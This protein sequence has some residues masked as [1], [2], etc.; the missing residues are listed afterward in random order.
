VG[1]SLEDFEESYK[2]AVEAGQ[3]N[4]RA[5][6]LL[7]NWCY[8][9]EFVRSAGRGMIEAATGLPIGHMGVQC[10]FSKKNTMHSWLLE[11][12]A[13]DFYLNNCKDCSERVAVGIPNIM[14][15]ITPR[16]EAARVRNQ[17]R[18]AEDTKRKAEQQSRREARALLRDHLKIEETFVLDLLDEL[19]EDDVNR[20][21]PRLEQLANLA[22]ESFTRQIIDHLLPHVLYQQLPYSAPGAKALLRTSL[23]K[24]EKVAVAVKLVGGYDKS[25]DATAVVL[26]HADLLTSDDLSK[27]LRRFTSLALGPPPGMHMGGSDPVRL[28]ATPVKTLYS[29]RRGD[30]CDVVEKLIGDTSPSKIGGAVEI[31]LS[32]LDDD[33]LQKHSRTIFAKLMR[34]R[35]LLPSE[36]RDSSVLYYLREAASRCLD[37]FP[38]EADRIIQSFLADGDDTGKSEAFRIYRSVLE[39]KYDQEVEIGN[40]QRI[41]FKRLLWAAVENPDAQM[42]DATQFFQHSWDEFAPLAVE[43]FDDLIGAAATLSERYEAV[44][45]KKSLEVTSDTLAQMD[46]RSKRTA[47]DSLQGALIEW[48]AVGARTKGRS[49]VQE[50]LDLYRRLPEDQTQMRGNMISHV[51]KLLSGVESL[52]WVLSDWYRALMDESTLVR[53][54]AVQAWEKVPYDL[55]QHFPDLFFEALA[56]SFS[57]P[58]VI[59]HRS[60][61]QALRRRSIPKDK[62]EL[63]KSSIWNLILHYANEDKTNEFTVDCIDALAYLCLSQDERQ[64]RFGEVLTGILLTLEGA[65]LYRAVDRLLYGFRDVP[66]F[67][68]VA[69]KALQDDYTRSISTDDCVTAILRAPPE[70]LRE[71]TAE[72]EKAFEGLK[73]FRKEDF[74]ETIFL[75]AVFSKAGSFNVGA[76]MFKQLLAEIP[77]EERN[78][79]WRI[80]TALVTTALEI[81]HAIGDAEEISDLSERWAGIAADLENENEERAKLRDF[82]PRFLF[83]D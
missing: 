31:I 6:K 51:S 39:N 73:P 67:A 62:R 1:Q 25:S 82:P 4:L 42:D 16:E 2:D 65:A 34:R 76:T 69:L 74:L 32:V 5:T 29:K 30:I 35:N 3:R 48:A 12:S 63:V 37:L 75:A 79:L 19:D 49:G 23:E 70:E 38:D 7:R 59:V 17:A 22:P 71:S 52:N 60:A 64:G 11:D 33:L 27:V 10:K 8:H 9:A 83:E 66:G 81:E 80:E 14:E 77:K 43:H 13:Y 55:V 72:L 46:I 78:E 21:D 18:E 58:Y 28:D 68:K 57:D 26:E 41:A 15:F 20:N 53:A 50:F 36:R 44:G 47:I 45:A 54:S 40:A 61:V 24:T 56:V